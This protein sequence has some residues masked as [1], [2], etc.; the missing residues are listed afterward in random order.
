MPNLSQCHPPQELALLFEHA[1]RLGG[2]NLK[3]AANFFAPPK[4]PWVVRCAKTVG[5]L[6]PWIRSIGLTFRT[7]GVWGARKSRKP[8]SSY[9]PPIAPRKTPH[10]RLERAGFAVA[11]ALVCIQCSLPCINVQGK[12][13]A[14]ANPE[15]RFAWDPASHETAQAAPTANSFA[16]ASD[17]EKRLRLPTRHRG[18][19]C[20][21]RLGPQAWAMTEKWQSPAQATS[22]PLPPHRPHAL[23]HWRNFGLVD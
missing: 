13:E 6:P 11:L 7:W 16:N 23:R 19:G 14:S 18:R 4:P 22:A 5:I 10:L 21:V 1:G 8:F 9:C 12:P 17:F 2:D 3:S 15:K 20:F